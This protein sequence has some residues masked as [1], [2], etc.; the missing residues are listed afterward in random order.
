MLDPQQFKMVRMGSSAYLIPVEDDSNEKNKQ[1]ANAISSKL[2]A[3]KDL[4][5]GDAG[6]NPVD[7]SQYNNVD[8]LGSKKSTSTRYRKI[9]SEALSEPP[10]Y[11]VPFGK[12][13]AEDLFAL[14]HNSVRREVQD[15]YYIVNSMYKRSVDLSPQ[16]V[17]DFYEWLSFFALLLD[18]FFQFDEKSLMHWIESRVELT[19]HVAREQRESRAERAMATI[20]AIED[21]RFR[22]EHLPPGEVL[23]TLKVSME[24]LSSVLLEHFRLEEQ[25]VIPAV[26]GAFSEED[27]KEF[28]KK[29]FDVLR[30]M[31]E[32]HT[33]MAMLM[34]SIKNEERLREYQGKYLKIPGAGFFKTVRFKKEY[35]SA[36]RE[37]HQTH[38]R[39]VYVFFDRWNEAHLGAEDEQWQNQQ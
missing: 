3:S 29:M 9:L 11:L 6:A 1:M 38:T 28:E 39:L 34:R 22:F 10:M 7:P 18:F 26:T 16:D 2:I 12:G 31:D 33:I 35:I 8:F 13:W 30:N 36:K 5:G 23:P 4:E 25:I 21:C 37:F 24:K 17:S 14:L 20:D 27:G 32:S 15:L 19:D